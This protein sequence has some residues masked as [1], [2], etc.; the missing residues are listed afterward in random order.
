MLT[1]MLVN[2][3]IGIVT[4]AAPALNIFAVGFPAMVLA[5][6]VLVLVYLVNI[7][8]RIEWLWLE[9]FQRAQSIWVVI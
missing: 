3:C 1:M 4:R 5:G 7:T 6:M 2:L 8:S 9:A